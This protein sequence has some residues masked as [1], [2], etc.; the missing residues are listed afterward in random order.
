MNKIMDREIQWLRGGIE[1]EIHER[2]VSERRPAESP[3]RLLLLASIHQ[4][5]EDLRAWCRLWRRWRENFTHRQFMIEVEFCRAV[6]DWLMF[7]GPGE[8]RLSFREMC[9]Y[10]ELDFEEVRAGIYRQFEERDI[11]A[12]REAK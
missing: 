12:L 10:C 5:V 7:D 11:K 2:V 9:D 3:E 4:A 1:N 8:V 6:D